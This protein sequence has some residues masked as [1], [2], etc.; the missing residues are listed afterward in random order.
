MNVY[1]LP[2][3]H[4]LEVHIAKKIDTH[5]AHN[6]EWRQ[7]SNGEWFVRIT[8]APARA[9][10]LGRTEAPGDNLLQTLTLLDTLKRNG[11]KGITL[12]VP[13]FGYAR[14]DRATQ[15]GDHIPA[16]LFT[17]L[18]KQ[19]GAKRILTLD[20][21]NTITEQH[22][23]IPLVTID[24]IPIFS[25]ALKKVLRKKELFTIVS[26]DHGSRHRAD[27]LR[28]MLKP[29]MPVCW[30]EK[31]RDPKTGN[32]HVRN[33]IGATRGV[34]AIIIDDICDTGG[35]IKE[36]VKKLKVNGFKTLF[37]VVTHPVF[38]ANAIQALRTLK[39]NKI[40]VTNTIRLSPTVKKLL[41]IT[42]LDATQTILNAIRK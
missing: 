24:S 18:F 6:T 35:T 22:S 16:D 5:F 10:V 42:V 21:H 1:T 37:L 25:K 38:S 7:F 2:N 9:I 32:V 27:R 17:K 12:V 28:D 36:C 3:P 39:F 30:L 11:T 41:P 33:L 31:H 23:P 4:P 26:P 13:Y 14:Q 29:T 15:K 34:T 40:F 19:C 8:Q 20:L